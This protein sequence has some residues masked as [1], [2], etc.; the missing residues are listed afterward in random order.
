MKIVYI[1]PECDGTEFKEVGNSIICA[2]DNCDS[3][4][5]KKEEIEK[6]HMLIDK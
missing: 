1:C 5:I 4:L 2:N 3:W 6:D